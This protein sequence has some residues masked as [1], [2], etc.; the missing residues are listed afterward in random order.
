[1]QKNAILEQILT[2]AGIDGFLVTDIKNLRYITGFTGSSGFLIVN[3]RKSVFVTDFRYKEQAKEEVKGFSIKIEKDKLQTINEIVNALKIKKLG[4]EAGAVSFETYRKLSKKGIKFKGYTNLIED[5]RA[6]KS[7]H[8]IASIKT[9]VR[10]AEKAFMR[11]VPYIRPGVKEQELSIRLECLLKEEGCKTL[12]FEVIVASGPRSSLPH[13]RPSGRVLRKG[14]IVLFDWGGESNGYFSDMSRTILLDGRGRKKSKIR[15]ERLQIFSTV[16][17]SQKMAI[18]A[19][20]P[21]VAARSIDAIARNFIKR[22]GYGRYFG[23][24]TGHGIGLSVH[25]APIISWRSKESLKEG[26]VFTIEPGIYIPGLGGVRIEN[27]VVVKSDSV[28]VLNK[29]PEE[30]RLSS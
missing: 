12:P 8:E 30:I 14:D 22:A 4:F 29:L 16:L 20:R 13:A 11:V 17:E 7:Q 5:M 19:I 26:M 27:M 21:G 9:A 6:I 3:A 18:K 28:E 23:H 15:T 1:M 25:E 2:V 10:R 24:G